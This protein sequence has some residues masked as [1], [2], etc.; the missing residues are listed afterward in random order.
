MA[1]EQL[2]ELDNDIEIDKADIRILQGEQRSGKSTTATALV[3]CDVF[4]MARGLITPNGTFIKAKALVQ[5]EVDWLVKSGKGNDEDIPLRFLRVFAS[6]GKTSKIIEKPR[7]WM[8]DSPVR[9]FANFHFFGF[10]FVL[11]DLQF[12]IEHMNSMILYATNE[13]PV[14]VILDES[15]MTEKRDTMT[16][17]GKDM[18][19]MGSQVGKSAAHMIIIT[20][21]LDM[22]QSRFVRFATTKVLCSYNKNTKMVHIDV[23]KT[24]DVMRSCDFDSTIYRRFYNH[25]EKV[26]IPE[27]RQNQALKIINPL[28]RVSVG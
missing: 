7:D 11:I 26:L 19:Q 13:S 21:Y 10:R 9:V 12:M 27:Y 6:D 22:V 14:W 16:V 24:S 15:F 23:N 2:D 25:R 5:D 17:V 28:N 8:V 4:A 18:A 20:Q 3:S 1:L